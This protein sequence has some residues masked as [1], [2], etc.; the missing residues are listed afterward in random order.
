MVYDDGMR[1]VCAVSILLG[2]SFASA[3]DPGNV[4]FTLDNGLRV[5]LMPSESGEMTAL[6]T[7][8]DFGER[9]NPP[10]KSGLA[11]LIEHLYVTC[12]TENVPG[13]TADEWFAAYDYKVNAQT[14]VDYT[15]IATIFKNDR[16]EAELVEAAE[17]MVSL[18]IKP[19]DLQRELPRMELELG[20][21][22]E[23]F[24][25]L[26]AT[27]LARNAAAPLA[28]GARRGGVIEQLHSVTIDEARAWH[29]SYYK[30][31]HARLIIAGAFDPNHVRRILVREY[32]KLPTGE[33]LPVPVTAMAP[34]TGAIREIEVQ[35]PVF[36]MWPP[37]L[38]SLAFRVPEPGSDLY[39]PFLMIAA[40]LQIR[41][42]PEL[43][44]IMREQQAG[45]MRLAP[46]QFA[47][48]D[49]PDVIYLN[50]SIEEAPFDTSIFKTLHQMITKEM[51]A[52]SNRN[53]YR[54]SFLNIYGSM[55]GQGNLQMLMISRNPYFAAF[56]TGRLDQM[57][58]DRAE[59]R[60]AIDAV[61]PD[62]LV[63]CAEEV[64]GESKGAGVLVRLK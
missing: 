60:A 53:A 4:R 62:D 58:I 10:E 46:V 36:N 64:F 49:D 29:R 57:G 44:K 9:H 24:P 25:H 22:Y 34:E 56:T 5:V 17:R 54:Q 18:N 30:P 23:R 26:T 51:E 47:P 32:G 14:G 61:T 42:M 39:A 12:A 37:G 15:V 27:N 6:V 8:F 7:L 2:V 48:L 11:H 55:F 13:R 3:Q 20:N 59:L 21:M 38:A 28:Q 35:T 43:Q 41:A 16:I 33:P 1:L 19:A 40:R 63:R 52:S 50:A 45:R 31:R